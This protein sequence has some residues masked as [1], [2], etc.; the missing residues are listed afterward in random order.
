MVPPMILSIKYLCQNVQKNVH[1]LGL[2]G[3]K[4]SR[5]PE[6]GDNVLKSIQVFEQKILRGI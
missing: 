1:I 5:L 4:Q 3:K 2:C 6:M